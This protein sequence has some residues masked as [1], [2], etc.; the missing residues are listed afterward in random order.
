[1]KQIIFVALFLITACSA[2]DTTFGTLGGTLTRTPSAK[3]NKV[4]FKQGVSEA[5][6]AMALKKC[7]YQAQSTSHGFT[8]FT[9]DV[10]RREA[11][12][13]D[14]CM[15]SEGFSFKGQTHQ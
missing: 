6:T 5:D 10:V 14:L 4:W 9:R 12:L 15:E 7:G 8:I 3:P 1:M 11:E 2:V 13:R